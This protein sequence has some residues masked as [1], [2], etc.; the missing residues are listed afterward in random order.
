MTAKRR[1][2]T[3]ARRLVKVEA[4]VEALDKRVSVAEAVMEREFGWIRG[5]FLVIHGA[6]QSIVPGVHKLL[7][8]HTTDERRFLLD[9]VNV[10]NAQ[11]R[12]IYNAISN[13]ADILNVKDGIALPD[14]DATNPGGRD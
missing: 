5:Q 10:M 11:Q 13:L 4:A 14:P 12:T 6:L 9:H 2:P 3:L 8:D 1:P 7:G